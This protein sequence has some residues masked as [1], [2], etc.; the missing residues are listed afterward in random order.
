M[1]EHI[2][3]EVPQK[4][5]CI[6]C[7]SDIEK[8]TIKCPRCL[9]FV[10]R[11]RWFRNATTALSVLSIVIAVFALAL[12]AIKLLL[13]Q[14]PEL[15][16]TVL[17]AEGKTFEFMVSNTGNR[18]AVIIQAGLE[19]PSTYKGNHLANWVRLE[20]NSFSQIIIEPEK[21]YRF[22]SDTMS[23]LAPLQPNPGLSVE[24]PLV[25]QTIPENCSLKI[26]YV[27]FN[28]FENVVNKPYRCLAD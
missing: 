2:V 23:G 28:G 11:F 12:P 18:P 8:D 13:P 22:T 4:Y 5:L 21:T 16:V 15:A 19:F 27:D 1:N 7:K 14:K 3:S 25:I 20:E 6:Y 9:S 10:G 26:V 24:L 17:K